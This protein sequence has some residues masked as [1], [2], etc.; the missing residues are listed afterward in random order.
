MLLWLQQK[1]AFMS[2][3]IFELTPQQRVRRFELMSGLFKQTLTLNAVII[4]SVLVAVSDLFPTP[5]YSGWLVASAWLCLLSVMGCY[6]SLWISTMCS[7]GSMEVTKGDIR[8][9]LPCIAIS[10]IG[11]IGALMCIMFFISWNL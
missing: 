1:G 2:S 4:V 6:G 8:F 11:F 5:V 7:D 10:L 9:L 3:A